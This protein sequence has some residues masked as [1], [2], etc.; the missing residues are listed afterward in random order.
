MTL[1]VT[2][3]GTIE[4]HL[5]ASHIPRACK[6]YLQP[7]TVVMCVGKWWA[8]TQKDGNTSLRRFW[9]VTFPDGTKDSSICCYARATI[10]VFTHQIH[11]INGR[12]S[13]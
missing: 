4:C 1:G 6:V 10:E 11:I 3:I 7:G 8:C 5:R 9:K 13:V 12:L 2:Y